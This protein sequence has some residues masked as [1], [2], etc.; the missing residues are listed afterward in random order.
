MA[1]YPTYQEKRQCLLLQFK[2]SQRCALVP[3]ML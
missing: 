3:V 1:Q 2:L